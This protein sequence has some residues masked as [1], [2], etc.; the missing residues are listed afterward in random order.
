M[1]LLEEDKDDEE[2]KGDEELLYS[3][4]LVKTIYIIYI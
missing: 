4:L 3:L 2:D 1:E